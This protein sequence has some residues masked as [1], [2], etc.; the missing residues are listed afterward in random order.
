MNAPT[1]VSLGFGEEITSIVRAR[2]SYAFRVFAAIYNY[3]VVE[4]SADGGAI[5][6]E[7][8]EKP[9]KQFGVGCFHVPARYDPKLPKIQAG[10][11]VKHRYANEKSNLS[12][13]C[14]P[15]TG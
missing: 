9:S 12:T 11:L 14:E 6:F 3:R 2:I 5:C 13:G 1:P 4:P 10:Q 8:T 7:Y 15:S